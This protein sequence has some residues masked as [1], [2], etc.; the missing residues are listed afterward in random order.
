MMVLLKLALLRSGE[1]QYEL[2]SRLGIGETR[3][4]RIVRG[5]VRPT[6]EERKGIAE[7]LGVPEA[8]LFPSTD[9]SGAHT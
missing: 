6:P 1:A 3:L 5:R 7:E 8:D 2:A 9:Q 4:S